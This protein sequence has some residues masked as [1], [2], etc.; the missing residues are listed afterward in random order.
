[1]LV[2]FFYLPE[3]RVDAEY[4]CSPQHS[5]GAPLFSEKKKSVKQGLKEMNEEWV[6]LQ[7]LKDREVLVTTFL[8]AILAFYTMIF[9]E[10]FAIWA[11]YG[12][13]PANGVG[14]GFSSYDIGT[15]YIIGG[16]T[17]LISQFLIFP[18]AVQ[19]FGKL[20]LYQGSAILLVFVHP[21]LPLAS[22]LIDVRW[23]VWLSVGAVMVVR[24]VASNFVF[25]VSMLLV[26]NSAE[27]S[28]LG[29][30]NGFAQTFCSLLRS[31][32]PSVGGSLLAWSLTNGL[33]FPLDQYFCYFFISFCALVTFGLTF[34]LTP[35]IENRKL[36]PLDEQDSEDE[37]GMGKIEPV[38]MH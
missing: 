5:E 2:G 7:F 21:C 19:Y 31:F 38:V 37:I 23:K 22:F 17:L 8:Y 33:P 30:A 1:L 9:D 15:S 18:F 4:S 6:F 34:L 10:V 11:T 25:T 29:A 28:K 14:I 13:D 20:R 35:S 36:P 12:L 3:T 16:V 27:P 32:A 26:N 24:A